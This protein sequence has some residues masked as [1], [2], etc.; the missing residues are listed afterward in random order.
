MATQKGLLTRQKRT[1]R[2]TSIRSIN[3]NFPL[4]TSI[5]F[6]RYIA[7]GGTI[8]EIIAYLER[9]ERLWGRPLA[10]CDTARA[11]MRDF[12]TLSRI[13]ISL[14]QCKN[15][16]RNIANSYRDWNRAELEKERCL[17]ELNRC[18]P[19]LIEGMR[20][21]AEMLTGWKMTAS[22]RLIYPRDRLMYNSKLRRLQQEAAK[23]TD[24]SD[25]EAMA[26]Q[27]ERFLASHGFEVQW[28]IEALA[29][30][31]LRLITSDLSKDRPSRVGKVVPGHYAEFAA[32]FSH[33]CSIW[34]EI[35]S[36][37]LH[38]RLRDAIEKQN[39]AYTK[40][41]DLSAL[42]PDLFAWLSSRWSPNQPSMRAKAIHRGQHHSW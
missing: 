2:P 22:E 9:I 37:R 8:P 31:E 23:L 15:V 36:P 24:L 18:I 38:Q 14:P 34:R 19:D 27:I 39:G 5:G 33:V 1:Q 12:A 13:Q 35:S 10:Q 11:A 21:C 42:P 30:S 41:Y 6:V 17:S 20:Q 40:M 32:A 26:Q 7:G 3:E 29:A 4:V 28:C 16:A 25:A